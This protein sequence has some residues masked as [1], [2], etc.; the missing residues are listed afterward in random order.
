M[1]TLGVARAETG[2]LGGV[3]DLERSIVIAQAAGSP[4]SV[5]AFLNLGSILA[6]L[7][8]LPR[9][10]ALHE[11]GHQAAERFG[12]LGGIRWLQA[13]RLYADY[14]SGRADDALRRAEGIIREVEAGTSHRMEL[15]ARLIRGWIRLERGDLTEAGRRCAT[16]A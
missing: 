6:R 12:D 10:F 9:A 5:R 1:C 2:D 3:E 8:D 15:D 4:E 14:W 13:E 16:S 7:G 11:E